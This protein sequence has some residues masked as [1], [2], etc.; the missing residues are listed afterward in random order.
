VAS[1]RTCVY[2]VQRIVASQCNDDVGNA[3]MQLCNF[4][5]SFQMSAT[6]TDDKT[7]KNRRGSSKGMEKL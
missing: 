4:V 6:A 2:S 7:A 3:A 1:R 5:Y